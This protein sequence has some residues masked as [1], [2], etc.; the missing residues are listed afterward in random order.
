MCLKFH[1]VH[2][3]QG[4]YSQITYGT[5]I[6]EHGTLAHIL[7]IMRQWYDLKQS[8]YAI[9]WNVLKVLWLQFQK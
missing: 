2:G 6:T 4:T 8:V 7:K 3:V 5:V 9:I 1:E